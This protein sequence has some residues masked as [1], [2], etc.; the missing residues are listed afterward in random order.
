MHDDEDEV[1]TQSLITIQE[2]NDRRQQ[3]KATYSE[4]T[5]QQNT[6]KTTTNKV[7]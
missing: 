4:E 1:Q 6:E 5:K 7:N 3:T 2:V